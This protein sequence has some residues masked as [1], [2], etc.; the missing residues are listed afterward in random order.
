MRLIFSHFNYSIHCGSDYN[1]VVYCRE[2][3]AHAIQLAALG[4]E[5][6][7]QLAKAESKA[8]DEARMEAQRQMDAE[9]KKITQEMEVKLNELTAQI[10]TFE[11]V[12]V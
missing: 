5:L 8:K 4:E 9:R 6:D 12:A 11:K 2:R 7:N 10:K 3:E 1:Y